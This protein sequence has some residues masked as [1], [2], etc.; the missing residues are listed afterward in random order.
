[1]IDKL[2]I[3]NFKAFAKAEIPL[4]PY[5]L[6]SGLNSSGK[7]TVLQALA[8]LRQA[9]DASMLVDYTLIDERGSSGSLPLNGE[10]VELGT[11]QDILHEDY[12]A[13]QGR[14]PEI[15]FEVVVDDFSHTILA[16]YGREDDLLPLLRGLDPDMVHVD[17]DWDDE[18]GT[19]FT[20]FNRGF[21]YLRAD[22]IN[23]AVTYPRSHEMAVRRG[24]LGTRGEY[25]IDFLRHNQDE[26]VTATALHHPAASHR[27]PDQLEAWMGEICPGVKISTAAI[28]QTDLV[29]LGFEFA[30]KGHLRSNVRRPTNVGFGLT[31]VLPVVVACLTA[32]PGAM[33]L[34]ENP[35]AHVHPQGQS[36]LAGLTCAAAAA[37]A[38]VIVETHSDHILNGVRL[39]VKREQIPADDVRLL[40]FHRKDDG[41]IDI[42]NPTIGPDGMLSEWPQGFFD[43][44][45]RSLDR[46][47][48]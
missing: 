44:W 22:R 12:A 5:T 38:Q 46:L 34:L 31:Y 8:L 10:L 19:A 2:T 32:R 24:F 6:L 11:G 26:T 41:I 9:D 18:G 30:R 42:V 15:G 20:L 45:D 1:M 21:Q 40:Y 29:R 39:A 35:E 48:D 23:P 47:L 25:T 33:I 43:E 4:A 16:R 37:G 36:A 14:V 17:P 3:T 27:L 7:S 13:D 28:E